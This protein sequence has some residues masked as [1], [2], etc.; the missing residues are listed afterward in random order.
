MACP[1]CEPSPCKR[2]CFVIIRGDVIGGVAPN[3]GPYGVPVHVFPGSPHCRYWTSA[4]FWTGSDCS[5]E[6]CAENPD[7]QGFIDHITGQA[8][9][10]VTIECVGV[11]VDGVC[12]PFHGTCPECAETT[13]ACFPNNPPPPGGVQCPIEATIPPCVDTPCSGD[14]LV[15]Y[16]YE[17]GGPSYQ[18]GDGNWV[19]MFHPSASPHGTNPSAY[20][21]GWC[22]AHTLRVPTDCEGV[23]PLSGSYT[24]DA[25]WADYEAALELAARGV[26]VI[27]WV[28]WRNSTERRRSD[29]CCCVA[30]GAAW[31]AVYSL[32]KY[33]SDTNSYED[34]TGLVIKRPVVKYCSESPPVGWEDCGPELFLG[35]CGGWSNGCYIPPEPKMPTITGPSCAAGENPLP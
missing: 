23:D 2:F 6:S 5:D 17:Y 34:I 7:V 16:R 4:T 27:P 21:P 1:C 31:T 24:A 15:S 35:D 10:D 33:N 29:N 30:G 9:G 11:E 8:P 25:N 26:P 32:W 22:D 20:L 3:S 28:D 19:S 13:Y 14:E 18:C 12:Y